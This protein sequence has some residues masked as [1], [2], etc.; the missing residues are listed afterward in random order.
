MVEAME[1]LIELVNQLQGACANFAIQQSILNCAIVLHGHPFHMVPAP[2]LVA[3][4]IN[5]I[6]K[7]TTD[8][9]LPLFSQK[10]NTMFYEM[11]YL[12]PF[13]MRYINSSTIMLST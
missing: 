11:N 7:M 4:G 9:H 5:N 1:E 8:V 13:G 3:S 10:V 6:V 2:Q 12:K